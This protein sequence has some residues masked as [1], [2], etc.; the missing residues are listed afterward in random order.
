M[1]GA[2]QPAVPNVYMAGSE[3]KD[4]FAE[5]TGLKLVKVVLL[6]AE[7]EKWSQSRELTGRRLASVFHA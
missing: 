4:V 6:P 2:E 5:R 7:C 1:L 3:S